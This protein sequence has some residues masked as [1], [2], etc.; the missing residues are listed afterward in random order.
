MIDNRD[1]WVLV[2]HRKSKLLDVTFEMLK[3]ARG[4]GDTLKE[5]IVA[6]VLGPPETPDFSAQLAQHGAD[7]V[8]IGRHPELETYQTAVFVQVLEKAC[9]EYRPSHFILP[10]T[11]NGQDLGAR[12]AARLGVGLV[13]LCVN[14]Q[15]GPDG[16]VEA[17]KEMYADKVYATLAC[18]EKR[19]HIFTFK[20]G[21]AGVDRPDENRTAEVI[22]LVVE[23][24]M[25]TVKTKT[26]GFV[27]AD[28]RTIDLMDA[29]MIISG[30][31]GVGSKEMFAV[32]RDLAD[33]MEASLGGTRAALDH[34]WINHDRLIG[35]T[36]K[37]VAPKLYFA[38]GISGASYHTMGIKSSE[39]IIALN[40]DKGAEI[41][42][43]AQLASVGDLKI[44]LP[45]LT[46]RLKK[47]L[48][49]KKAKN[50]LSER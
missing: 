12:L 29:D 6:I 19:P 46:E 39:N 7:R 26:L 50:T 1:I 41:F 37:M 32:L 40:I 38:V 3:D 47:H 45:L 43:L 2:C 24:D 25:K 34:D 15:V 36:G 30:G 42:K 22:D 35:L 33:T 10:G 48:A 28:P 20:P 13:S 4:L 44:I 18:G 49:N 23:I 17:N 31:R 14:F 27:P 5:K 8:F 9:H 21:A 16:V 11:L